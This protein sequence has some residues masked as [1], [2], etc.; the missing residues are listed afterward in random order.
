[1]T[2]PAITCRQP[3]AGLIAAGLK[4]VENRGAN[5]SLRGDIAIHAG[6]QVDM[7]EMLRQAKAVGDSAPISVLGAVL[8]VAELVDCH[9][10]SAALR[11]RCGP[12][13]IQVYNGRPAYHLV[14]ANVR[15][16]PAPVECRGQVL[17]GWPLPNDV[18]AAVRAQLP[19]S[20]A[21]LKE[22]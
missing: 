17:I 21:S 8:A 4:L 5:T 16:L 6:K 20:P 15:R 18:D 7:G 2:L 19:H 12:Y 9:P 13:G 10:A 3:W 11:C 22:Q 14:L 1:M